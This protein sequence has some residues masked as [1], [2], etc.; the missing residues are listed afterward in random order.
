MA[1]DA[2]PSL[3]LLPFLFGLVVGTASWTATSTASAAAPEP[4][5]WSGVIEVPGRPLA[6][7]VDLDRHQ[8]RWSGS[9]TLPGLALAGHELTR[10]TATE[11]AISFQIARSLAVAPHEAATIHLAPSDA[12]RM[13]GEFRQG[14]LA[15]P[16]VLARAGPA[17][18]QV[19][20]RSTLVRAALQGSWTGRYELGGY[21]REV[22]IELRNVA[23]TA[24]ATARLVIVGKATTEIP[25]DLVVED[26]EFLALSSSA[27]RVGFEGRIAKDAVEIRGAMLLGGFELPMTLTR[28]APGR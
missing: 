28:K 23:D 24:S 3:R 14:G 19:P 26:G 25:V 22:T 5:R 4:G 11:S 21:P 16:V 13:L 8:G 18:V 6:V 9:I 20:I 1:P 15:A 10:I 12:G 27:T 2:M 17:Q 7:V